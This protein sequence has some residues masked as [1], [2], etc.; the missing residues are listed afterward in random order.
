MNS[1]VGRWPRW[2]SK[3]LGRPSSPL[4]GGPPLAGSAA[5]ATDP[6]GLQRSL[7]GVFDYSSRALALVWTTNK[8]LSIALALMT[9][10]GGVLPAGVAYVGA[11]IVD[12]VI[13]AA[14]LHTHAGTTSFSHVFKYVGLE[15][16]LIA[17]T[18]MAQRGISLAQS[19]LRAQL[20]QRVNVMILETALTLDLTQF[21]DSDFYDKLPRARREASSRPLSL[22]MRTFGLAQ[23]AI[24]LVS[25]GSLLFH[26]SPWAVVVLLLSGLPAFVAEARFSG[27]AFRLFRWRSPETRMQIYLESVLGREEHA[28]EVRLFGLGA[29]LV[30]RYRSMFTTLSREDRALPIRRDV[31]GFFLGLIGTC[32]LYLAYAW[33]ALATA[34][35]IITLGKMSMYL[36]LFRQGQSA[37][38]AALSSIG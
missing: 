25:Y 30:D 27:D 33:I 32:A 2:S 12:A 19:L 29:R 4:S 14:D 1:E 22:V 37:V 6:A 36:G 13:H 26:F 38:S 35:G 16:L 10:G 17:A 5:P 7:F 15:A 3:I 34:R 11:Q 28:K 23:N 20:G 8:P 24:S 9:L 21:E 18:S 31:W